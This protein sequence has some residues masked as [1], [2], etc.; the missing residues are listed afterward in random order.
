MIDTPFNLSGIDKDTVLAWV[1]EL[2]GWTVY[3]EV[4]HEDV[5]HTERWEARY[6]ASRHEIIPDDPLS[7]VADVS[8]AQNSDIDIVALSLVLYANP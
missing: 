7:V 8:R 2:P 5:D 4:P 6:G 1:D 3:D